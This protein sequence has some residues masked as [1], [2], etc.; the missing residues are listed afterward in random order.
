MH[1]IGQDADRNGLEG[2]TF[3]NRCVESTQAIDLAHQ[4]ITRS[5]GERYREEEDSTVDSRT[6]I[7]R[8]GDITS[9][10]C[11]RAGSACS[12]QPR[13]VGKGGRG[14]SAVAR[15]AFRRAHAV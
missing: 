7:S 6:A 4:Q 10:Y 12:A 13:R 9:A 11:S 5:I 2:Q 3:L 1:M 8:H 15:S 14:A